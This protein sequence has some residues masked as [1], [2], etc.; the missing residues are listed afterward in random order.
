M[1][2]RGSAVDNDV[3]IGA[4]VR[5][6]TGCYITA[7]SVIE[8]DVFVGPGRHAHQ[9]R[10]DGPPRPRARAARR[11]AAAGLPGGRRRRADSGG[12][13]RRG[14]IRGRGRGGGARRA[15]PG[16]G[17]G[18]PGARGARGRRTRTCW[19]AGGEAVASGRWPSGGGR[20]CSAGWPRRRWRPWWPSRSAVSGA[21]AARPPLTEA[22]D[23]LQAAAE[24]VAETAEV[25]RTGYQQ[26]STRENAMFNLLTSFFTALRARRGASPP[27]CAH[28][29]AWAR[30]ATCGW[31][32]ATS[33][34][35][36]PG[37]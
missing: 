16:G 33:T 26:V 3:T 9:R 31:G 8:D 36:C 22:D 35:S 25:A 32:A 20:W 4:R 34:T 23:A 5:I 37:S 11:P 13:D 2:G 18:R 14:G 12:G 6:Q 7:F 1:V 17:D 19:S 27:C 29:R 15:G 28:A 10:H 21:A 24:A 30:F